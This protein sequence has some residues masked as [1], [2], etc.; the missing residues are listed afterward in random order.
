MNPLVSIIIPIYNVEKYIRHCILSVLS[1]DFDHSLV[2]LIL[3]NDCTQDNSMEIVKNI[4]DKYQIENGGGMSIKILSHSKNRGLSASRNTGM[5][6]ASG[7]FVFFVDSDDYLFSGSIKNHLK[8]HNQY[9]EV[10]LI[11]GNYYDEQKAKNNYNISYPKIVYDM[12][13][14]F[15][16]NLTKSTAWNSMVRRKLLID[17]NIKFVEGI[18]FEDNVFNYQLIPMVKSALVIPEVTYFYRK[19][20]YGIMQRAEWE[21]IDKVV[22]DYLCILN[23]FLGSLYGKTYVGKSIRAF[24]ICIVLCD[25]INKHS[26]AISQM[27]NVKSQFYAVCRKMLFFHLRNAR[28]FL[29]LLCLFVFPPFNKLTRYGWFRHNC[30]KMITVSGKL[31]IG[32]DIFL[33]QIKS[34]KY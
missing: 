31:E 16:G 27:K 10:D 12:N 20:P 23:I 8:Y 14:L 24:S 5:S 7:E 4:I 13:S 2:E 3:I 30:G 17:N 29:F 9:P 28:L 21:M 22:N 15:M 25:N 11:I 1:Q 18:Y 32:R 6:N 26:I 34:C 19:N 33:N